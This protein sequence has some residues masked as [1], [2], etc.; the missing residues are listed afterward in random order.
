MAVHFF[1]YLSLVI[2]VYH[3]VSKHLIHHD[4]QQTVYNIEYGM[5]YIFYV[6]IN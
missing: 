4:N 3:G 1:P 2:T 5:K 6:V